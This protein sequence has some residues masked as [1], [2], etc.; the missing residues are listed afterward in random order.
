MEKPLISVIIP[1]YNAEKYLEQC[2]DSILNQTYKNLEVILVDDG[3]KDNSYGKCKLYAEKDNR[4]FVYHRSNSGV[5]NMRDYGLEMAGGDYITFLDPDDY[6][7]ASMYDK[8]YVAVRKNGTEA[9]MC[10]L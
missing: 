9:A 7:N 3:S 2:M 6:I 8:P 4:F 10:S 1:I 5:S